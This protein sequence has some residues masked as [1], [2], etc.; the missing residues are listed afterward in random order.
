MLFSSWHSNETCMLLL[1][2]SDSAVKWTVKPKG[3]C[4]FIIAWS[5][6]L[7]YILIILTDADHPSP[8]IQRMVI[9]MLVHC[10][11]IL[12]KCY[13]I[14]YNCIYFYLYKSVFLD[15]S[16]AGSV[17]PTVLLIGLSLTAAS[18]IA[19]MDLDVLNLFAIAIGTLAVP[20]LLFM[21]SFMLWPSSLIKVYYW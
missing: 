16:L 3:I 7:G 5:K 4:T 1:V 15:A 8:N 10:L 14:V 6:K 9:W 19:V 2:N 12:D 21:A 13:C 17:S 18:P 11:I 20:I